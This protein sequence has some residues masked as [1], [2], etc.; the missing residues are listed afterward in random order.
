MEPP[1][2]V[3][4]DTGD[5]E[6]IPVRGAILG[7]LPEWRETPERI[8]L[9]EGDVLWLFSDGLTEA[10]NQGTRNF[11][12]MRPCRDRIG[13]GPQRRSAEHDGPPCLGKVKEFAGGDVSDDVCVLVARRSLIQM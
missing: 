7:V 8:Q 12:A 2:V 6:E 10:R 11:S 1:L 9:A 5:A 4:A 13:N 3:R